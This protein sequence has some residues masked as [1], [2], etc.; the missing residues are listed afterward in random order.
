MC[1]RCARDH[2]RDAN[3]FAAVAS[4]LAVRRAKLLGLRALSLLIYV[5]E[6]W[7][8]SAK[9]N[10]ELARKREL[11]RHLVAEASGSG[12]VATMRN[13]LDEFL[14]GHQDLQVTLLRIRGRAIYESPGKV[15]AGAPQRAI[16]LESPRSVALTNRACADCPRSIW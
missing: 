11:V 2:R 15:N 1:W 13:K 8:L 7:S 5:A 4:L 16:S 10:A 9:A 6:L 12:D 3:V 14:L